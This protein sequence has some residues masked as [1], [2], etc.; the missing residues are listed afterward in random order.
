MDSEAYIGFHF[1]GGRLCIWF[2]GG[3]EGGSTLL[4]KK[5]LKHY[6]TSRQSLHHQKN[7]KF[8]FF[9]DLLFFKSIKT[10]L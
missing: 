10:T 2:L 5:L 7:K 1:G 9:N 6:K 4:R 3:K 8:N